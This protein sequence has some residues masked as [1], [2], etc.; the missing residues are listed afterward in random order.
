MKFLR[1]SRRFLPVALNNNWVVEYPTDT[2]EVLR[3]R[4]APIHAKY[5]IG[6]SREMEAVSILTCQV[7]LADDCGRLW[8]AESH[9]SAAVLL[10]KLIDLSRKE[11]AR[12]LTGVPPSWQKPGRALFTEANYFSDDRF[13]RYFYVD[14]TACFLRFKYLAITFDLFELDGPTL[15]ACPR[16]MFG[17]WN[18]LVLEEANGTPVA[19]PSPPPESC[20]G[21]PYGDHD[22]YPP[23][24]YTLDVRE[25]LFHNVVDEGWGD[26]EFPLPVV[27]RRAKGKAEPQ[28]AVVAMPRPAPSQQPAAEERFTPFG[29]LQNGPVHFQAGGGGLTASSELSVAASLEVAPG[30]EKEP[31]DVVRCRTRVADSAGRLWEAVTHFIPDYLLTFLHDLD[32]IS[33][34]VF[35]ESEEEGEPLLVGVR[36][37]LWDDGGWRHFFVDGWAV[38]VRFDGQK[39]RF[40]ILP[41][42]Q[43]RLRGLTGFRRP[44]QSEDEYTDWKTRDRPW[45][46]IEE[47]L[48]PIVFEMRPGRLLFRNTTFAIDDGFWH[49]NDLPIPVVFEPLDATG[50]PQANVVFT[51][52]ASQR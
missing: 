26:N 51:P 42:P 25:L 12:W 19:P 24:A 6:I 13:H 3:I 34:P 5:R 47:P 18:R 44:V 8:Q 9:F 48:P 16:G 50:E 36:G 49:H 38:S 11:P 43:V 4:P 33:M 7:R 40:D 27:F 1:G 29:L 31:F 32:W 37:G 28:P 20:E 35:E 46:V 2:G 30:S 22:E 21:E 45:P 23:M 15:L 17:S 52:H 39:P 14:N 41:G 10:R